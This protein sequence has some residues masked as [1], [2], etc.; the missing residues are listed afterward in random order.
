MDCAVAEADR[1]IATA[2]TADRAMDVGRCMGCSL[3][4][5]MGG[6]MY[7][8]GRA[9]RHCPGLALAGLVPYVPLPHGP[10]ESAPT[11]W[12]E[13]AHSPA[14]S[15]RMMRCAGRRRLAEVGTAAMVPWGKVA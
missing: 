5:F 2:V 4:A 3:R 9:C 11:Q 15:G 13:S 7:V 10:A 8:S 6:M 1:P 14:F 12:A